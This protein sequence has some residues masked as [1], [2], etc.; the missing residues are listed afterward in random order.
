M[1]EANIY[2]YFNQPNIPRATYNA[3]K[4]ECSDLLGMTTTRMQNAWADF[5]ERDDLPRRVRMHEIESVF[6]DTLYDWQDI[7]SR[8]QEAIGVGYAIAY[9]DIYEQFGI[10]DVNE[11]TMAQMRSMEREIYE[12]IELLREILVHASTRIIEDQAPQHD[13]VPE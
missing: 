8:A 3:F 7:V 4:Q 5:V 6:V 1:A 13:A 9:D 10:I 2:L 12:H 11:I